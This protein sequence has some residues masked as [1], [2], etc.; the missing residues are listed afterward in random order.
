MSYFLEKDLHDFDEVL[1]D[2]EH[3]A[4]D[5]MDLITKLANYSIKISGDISKVVESNPLSKNYITHVKKLH[6]EIIGKAHSS[7]LEGLPTVNP[8]YEREWPYPWGTRSALTVGRFLIAYGFLLKVANLTPNARILEVGCGMGSLT[9]NLARMGYRVDALDP[10]IAQCEIV[11]ESTKGFSAKPNIIPMTLDEWLDVKPD[12]YR[13]DAIIFFESFHHVIDHQACIDRLLTSHMEFDAKILLA[14]EPIFETTTDILPY[15]WGPRLDGES[16]RAMRR[17]GWLELGY[18]EDYLKKL[19]KKFGLTYEWFK[20]DEAAP[21]SQIVVGC[22]TN[23]KVNLSCPRELRYPAVISNGIDLSIN[24][25]P[26]F[27]VECSGLSDYE[28][29]GRW[30]LGD[31]VHFKLKHNL[32]GNIIIKLD[33]SGVFGPNVHKKIVISIGE[34]QSSAILEPIELCSSYS[35]AFDTINSDT[36]K[37][38]IP[39]PYRPKDIIELNNEDSRKIGIGIKSI[40]FIKV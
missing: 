39:H 38:I 21:L 6:E 14:A 13:Y 36:I 2:I 9:W 24:G 18:T 27:I 34:K 11:A 40:S 12:Y 35:F 33:L 1:Y 23:E 25:L 4:Q 26:E 30:S 3:N 20:C 37:I 19:F 31:N 16:L 22:M 17:W 28:G 15:P 29:W 10:N 5:N 7:S 32:T 8:E